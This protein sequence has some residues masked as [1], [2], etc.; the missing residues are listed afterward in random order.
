MEE[1]VKTFVVKRRAFY[2][3]VGAHKTWEQEV[4]GSISGS[5]NILTEDW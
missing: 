1:K 2:S 4:A 5:P 3:S